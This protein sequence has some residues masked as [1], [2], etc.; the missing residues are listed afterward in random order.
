MKTVALA[1]A[2]SGMQV[3]V[4]LDE[5]ELTTLVALVEQ[6]S[7]NLTANVSARLLHTAMADIAG[8]FCSLLGLLELAG[9][10]E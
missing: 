7:Q 2:E 3:T 1:K 8:E 9:A 5:L 4:E 10:D 6:G